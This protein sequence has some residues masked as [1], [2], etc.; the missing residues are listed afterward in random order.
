MNKTYKM[1]ITLV[2]YTLGS[3]CGFNNI[4]VKN[5]SLELILML[6]F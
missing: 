6:K 3:T 1:Y 5:S 2:C 4:P